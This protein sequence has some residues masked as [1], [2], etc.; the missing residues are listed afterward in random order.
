MEKLSF[1]YSLK[2][3]P[4]PSERSYK[5]KL[6][7][8]TEMLIKRMRWKAIFSECDEQT[9][10]NAYGLRSFKCPPQVKEL[11][12]FESDLIDLIKYVKFDENYR[13]SEFQKKLRKDIHT[14]TRSEKTLNCSR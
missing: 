4:I 13:P 2:N 11:L 9:E 8:K 12:N 6:M 10:K 1:G 5:L 14:I 3:I 7:E